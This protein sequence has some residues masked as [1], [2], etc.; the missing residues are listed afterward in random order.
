MRGEGVARQH[1]CELE[2]KVHIRPLGRSVATQVISRVYGMPWERPTRARGC[3]MCIQG[4]SV[5]D[6]SVGCEGGG[7]ELD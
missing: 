4:L 6:G 5:G 1:S 3:A 7:G 2:P